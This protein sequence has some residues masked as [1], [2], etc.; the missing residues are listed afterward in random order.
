MPSEV[1]LLEVVRLGECAGDGRVVQE[2]GDRLAGAWLGV[3]RFKDVEA[4]IERSL[5]VQTTAVTLLWAG[6]LAPTC[7]S[8]AC[9]GALRRLNDRADSEHGGG[10]LCPAATQRMVEA[11][12]LRSEEQ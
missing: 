9:R 4:L 2:V 3:S 5:R 10:S 8:G 11:V 7:R 12:L 1:E 6:R